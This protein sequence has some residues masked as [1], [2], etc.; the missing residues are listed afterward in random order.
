MGKRATSLDPR[1]KPEGDGE[2]RFIA[3]KKQAEH[4]P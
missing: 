3:G 1:V 4:R 2:C